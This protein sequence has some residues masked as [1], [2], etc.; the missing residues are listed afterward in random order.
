MKLTPWFNAGVKPVRP[1]I[2]QRQHKKLGFS[3]YAKWDG[4]QWC[5]GV[6][7]KEAAENYSMPSTNQTGFL[8]RGVLRG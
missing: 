1:G 3:V 2:Y 5:L 8:W 4:K 7:S 6:T